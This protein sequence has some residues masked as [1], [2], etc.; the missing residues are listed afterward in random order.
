MT[1]SASYAECERIAR[2]AASHFYPAF[3]ILPRAQRRA[4]YALYA[5]NR[6]TDDLADSPV[7]EV[8]PHEALTRWQII[9]DA[10]LDGSLQH[11][12]LTALA[13]TVRRFDIPRQYLHDVIAGCR[14]DLD[15]PRFETFAELKRYCQL[16]ASSVGLACI[17]IWGFHGDSAVEYADAAGIALQ[18]TNILRDLKEDQ[19]AGRLYLPLD[20]LQRFGCDREHIGS[21]AKC[22]SFQTLMQLEVERAKVY[23]EIAKGLD[24]CLNSTG[25]AVN[26][27]IVGTYRRLLHRI[28]QA[29]FDVFSKR[30][31]VPKRE[32]MAIVMKA[33]PARMGWT[34]G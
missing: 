34:R 7:D 5:F 18:L 19:T 25:R 11:P 12:Q 17:H 10:T 15:R 31:S 32:K 16:V 27:V 26:R 9:L 33:L 23:Y 4:M 21:D 6:M 28:E 1:I 20:D 29:N 13:D 24:G 30:I 2:R 14:L 22:E 8:D 3:L